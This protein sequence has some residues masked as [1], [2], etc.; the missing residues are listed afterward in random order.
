MPELADDAQQQSSWCEFRPVDL[1]MPPF[2]I[3]R[4]LILRRT[5]TSLRI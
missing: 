5:P 1:L 2:L 3:R 4:L